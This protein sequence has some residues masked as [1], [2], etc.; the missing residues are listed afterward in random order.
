MP[1]IARGLIYDV[2][3]SCQIARRTAI[4]GTANRLNASLRLFV[5]CRL[6]AFLDCIGFAHVLPIL[7]PPVPLRAF[8]MVDMSL[9]VHPNLAISAAGSLCCLRFRRFVF[10]GRWC[11]CRSGCWVRSSIRSCHCTCGCFRFSRVLLN[12]GSRCCRTR[13]WGRISGSN[14][15]GCR[16]G[17]EDD[18]S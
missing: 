5:L 2:A 4:R 16:E 6:V 1:E 9:T 15:G 14:Q 11:P 10:L 8:L 17:S 13:A 7:S 18:Q 12:R 3:P